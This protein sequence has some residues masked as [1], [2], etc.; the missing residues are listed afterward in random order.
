MMEQIEGPPAPKLEPCPNPWCHSHERGIGGVRIRN[1]L[2]Y[3][4]DVL[5]KIAYS[6]DSLY[7]GRCASC[8]L[9]GP[10]HS[11]PEAAVE[12]WNTRPSPWQPIETVPY[13][14]MVLMRL[15]GGN[16]FQDYCLDEGWASL[17]AR[18]YTHW[19]PIPPP[20]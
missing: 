20:P 7:V 13:D 9:E 17:A 4:D 19:M 8:G 10:K 12:A 2:R 6:D 3:A 11:T 5:G 16:V 1:C 14:T 15:K 18:G